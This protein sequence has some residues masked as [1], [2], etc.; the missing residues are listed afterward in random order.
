M[1]NWQQWG[2]NFW[3]HVTVGDLNSYRFEW[4][5]KKK[6]CMK[7]YDY[8]RNPSSESAQPNTTI[9]PKQK[10][11]PWITNSILYAK[12]AADHVPPAQKSASEP[13]PKINGKKSWS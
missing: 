6:V 1:L 2:T 9:A 10:C 12:T 8:E 13:A 7:G 3:S 5:T 11:P 4:F